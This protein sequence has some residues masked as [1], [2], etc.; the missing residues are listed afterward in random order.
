MVSSFEHVQAYEPGVIVPVNQGRQKLMEVLVT[1][2]PSSDKT[3]NFFPVYFHLD[4]LKTFFLLECLIE[5]L[6]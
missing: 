6:S 2:P 1:Q 4:F 3:A 5:R